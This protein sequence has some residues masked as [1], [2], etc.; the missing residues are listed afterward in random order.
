MQTK[1]EYAYEEV[2]VLASTDARSFPH[3]KSCVHHISHSN[4]IQE[5]LLQFMK[6]WDFVGSMS[7][8]EE[9]NTMNVFLSQHGY[10]MCAKC[11]LHANVP[12][13]KCSIFERP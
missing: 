1:H 11:Q 8:F 6:E 13:F 2:E 7:K 3:Y 9:E 5:N 4:H 10:H 12:R